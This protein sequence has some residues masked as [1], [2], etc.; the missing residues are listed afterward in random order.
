MIASGSASCPKCRERDEKYQKERESELRKNFGTGC[1]IEWFQQWQYMQ[2]HRQMMLEK[3]TV[4]E[5][6][7]TKFYADGGCSFQYEAKCTD[8]G[9][10]LKRVCPILT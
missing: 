9:F 5:K 3:T 10:R 6:V 2:Q 4:V 1:P 8:C 7:E